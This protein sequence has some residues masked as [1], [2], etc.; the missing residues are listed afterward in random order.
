MLQ[1]IKG[2]CPLEFMACFI[3]INNFERR[4]VLLRLQEQK[5]LGL[6]R[7]GII[8]LKPKNLGTNTN[9]LLIL[10]RCTIPTY[11]YRMS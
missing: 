6:Q 7:I 8:G 4:G 3:S 10:L 11:S 1:P 5:E 2:V 9:Q